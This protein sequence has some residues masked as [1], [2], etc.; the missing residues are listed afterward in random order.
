MVRNES[1][2]EVCVGLQS[3]SRMILGNNWMTDRDLYFDLSESQLLVYESPDC[4]PYNE[5]AAPQKPALRMM[6]ETMMPELP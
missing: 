4:K 5:T 1:A 2:R 6:Y 3:L